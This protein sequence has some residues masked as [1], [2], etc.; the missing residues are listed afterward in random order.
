MGTRHARNTVYLSSVEAFWGLGMNLLS[1]GT[2]L[3][4]FLQER[5][6]SNAVIAFLP[7]MS[8]L[9]A[10][11]P[12]V[13]S[14]VLGGN[15]PRL[16]PLVLWLHVAASLPLGLAGALL[17]WGRWPSAPVVLT[18]WALFYA[19]IGLVFPLWMDYMARILDPVVR[20]RALGIV[21]LTQT[22][23]GVAGVSLAAAQLRGGT[24]DARYAVLF[25]A[26]CA[27]IAGGS[28]FFLGTREDVADSEGGRPTVRAHLGDLA[29]LWCR[30]PWMRRYMLARWL[31]RGSY[32]LLIHFYAVYAVT[33]K[34]VGPAEAALYGTA[35]LACQALVGVFAGWLGDRLGHKTSVLLG[36][37]I[38][39]LACTVAVLPV[40]AWA[41]FVLAGLTGA[42][43]A[44]EY[45]SHAAWLMDLATPKERQAVM[46]L[47][48][49]LIT[50]ASVLA[51]LA[52]GWIMDA[53]GFR[54]VVC[55]VALIVA[56]AFIIGT[57]VPAGRERE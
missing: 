29:G 50:P 17:L 4:V 31:V 26:A 10:G 53:T 38:L 54:P 46:A 42:F 30:L 32:P 16:R 47:V 39:I 27:V 56:V 8:A 3:P 34:G 51:P 37:G 33:K 2:V 45:T 7:A 11:L 25:L 5:G 48:G 15:R 28:L 49:F 6:A 41:F 40:P 13:F 9:G 55:A 36:Q 52:G 22:L 20:G 12:Q 23:A 35:A 24:S 57:R 43:L 1:M 19:L 21:F 14:G 44:T 18:C